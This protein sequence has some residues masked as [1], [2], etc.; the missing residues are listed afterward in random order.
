[1]LSLEKAIGSSLS[2]GKLTIW[3]LKLFEFY[4]KNVSNKIR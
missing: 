1:M 2:K 3:N 4:Q